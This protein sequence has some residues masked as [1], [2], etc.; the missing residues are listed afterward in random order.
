MP[1]DD[2]AAEQSFLYDAFIS[3]RHVDRDRKWAEW[4]IAALEGYRVPKALQEARTAAAAAQD[5]SRRG[6]AS[7]LARPQR[8]D[9]GGAAFLPLSHCRLLGLHAAVEM[10]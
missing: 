2:Q 4:L 7:L 9:Q 10:G 5:L 6:R 3:Y 8:S 1:G